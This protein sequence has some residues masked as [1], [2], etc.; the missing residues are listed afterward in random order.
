MTTEEK[1]KDYILT[2]YHS[3]REFTLE[4][5]MPYTTLDSIFRRGIGNAGVNNIVK[6]CKALSISVDALAYGEI[7]AVPKNRNAAPNSIE[8]VEVLDEVKEILSQ[9]NGIT[10][11]G[12]P[13]DQNG[14]DSIIDTIDIGV[15]MAKRKN[16]S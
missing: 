12:K 7:V 3:I 14:V 2:K 8:I 10:L 1:L 15:E 13:L 6:I 11:E 5:D 16:N 4:I 9:H